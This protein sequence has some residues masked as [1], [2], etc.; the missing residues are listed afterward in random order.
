[1][2][3]GEKTNYALA[4]YKNFAKLQNEQIL[5]MSSI[6]WETLIKIERNELLDGELIRKARSF[7][8]TYSEKYHNL[9]ELDQKRISE[10]WLAWKELH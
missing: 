2:A 3:K 10:D 7:Q 1:M 5:E 9:D 4:S 6:V 8:N